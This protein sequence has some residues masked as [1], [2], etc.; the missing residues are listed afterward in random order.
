MLVD[1]MKY[2]V[3]INISKA[4]Y[5]TILWFIGNKLLEMLEKH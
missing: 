2:V 5:H 4:V 3:V 1:H